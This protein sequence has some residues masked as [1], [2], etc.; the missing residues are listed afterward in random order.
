VRRII[1]AG[2]PAGLLL[3]PKLWLSSRIYPQTPLGSGLPAVPPPFDWVVDMA[4][5]WRWRRLPKPRA[6]VVFLGLAVVL[7]ARDQ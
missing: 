1:V 2:L 5:C 3:S 6:A 4:C 7:V